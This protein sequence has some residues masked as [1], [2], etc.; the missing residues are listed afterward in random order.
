MDVTLELGSSGGELNK[1]LT[2]LRSHFSELNKSTRE[3]MQL[4]KEAAQSNVASADLWLAKEKEL[5]AASKRQAEQLANQKKMIK[6]LQEQMKSLKETGLD[7]QQAKK[8][9]DEI[10]RLKK[11]ID[12]LKTSMKV[13]GKEKVF[14][15]GSL[16][17]AE[18]SLKRITAEVKNLTKEQLKS[19][20]GKFLVREMKEAQKEVAQLKLEAGLAGKAVGSIEEGAKKSSVAMNALNKSWSFIRQAA[21]IIP[22]LGIAGMIGLATDAIMDLISAMQKGDDI[23]KNFKEINLEAGKAVTEEK[24]RLEAAVKV[25]KDKNATDE[26]RKNALKAI[27]DLMPD[28]IGNITAE[29]INTEEGTRLLKE[30]VKQ[31]D[32]K[33]RGQAY[34]TKIA[35]LY[36]QLLDV[37]N[38]AIEDNIKW[39]ERLWNVVKSGGNLQRQLT[40]DAT[41]GAMNRLQAQKKVQDQILKLEEDL[42]KEL[43]AGTARIDEEEEK[44]V[45]ERR[46][47]AF[48]D[49]SAQILALEKQLLD[50]RIAAMRE[51]R[52]KEIAQEDARYQ[53]AIDKAVDNARKAQEAIDKVRKEKNISEVDRSR[54][55]AQLQEIIKL[56]GRVEEEEKSSHRARLLAIDLKYYEDARK[57]LEASQ[58]STNEIISTGEQKEIAATTQKYAKLF[59]AIEDARKKAMQT[60]DSPLVMAGINFEF[61]DQIAK[62]TEAQQKEL[63]AITR[64]YNLQKIAEGEKLAISEAGILEKSG[65][66]LT[67]LER[68]RQGER[69]KV[70]IIAA[71][72]R[73]KL[74]KDSTATE[75]KIIVADMKALIVKLKDELK[76]LGIKDRKEFSIYSML[77]LND[78]DPQMRRDI[79]Q[80]LQST[81]NSLLSIWGDY[82]DRRVKEQERLMQKI[83]DDLAKQEEIVDREKALKEKGYA[84]DYDLEQR[85]LQDLKNRN[86]AQLEQLKKA[87]KEQAN[88]AKT[89]QILSG[90]ITATKLTVAAAEY[91]AGG[92]TYGPVAGAILSAAAIAA[93]FAAFSAAKSKASEVS[94][95][96]GFQVM[97]GGGEVDATGS[98]Y[99]RHEQGGI[100]VISQ[101]KKVAE[102]EQGE[103]MYVFKDGKQAKK[104]KSFF[105]DINEGR[106][107]DWR[108]SAKGLHLPKDTV[109]NIVVT[110]SGGGLTPVDN[111]HLASIDKKMTKLV[112][113]K[114]TVEIKDGKRIETTGNYIRIT[115]LP[116]NAK[117]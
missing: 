74:L 45:N 108:V 88:Y 48:Q 22:G 2:E 95:N 81:V 16:A 84:N 15:E 110:H 106:L 55:I 80:G 107:S 65:L 96:S 100:D 32:A 109:K 19:K 17:E 70:Q 116:K 27:N 6:E 113:E 36:N 33:A 115:K 11:Q 25:A 112:A 29:N 69:Y 38:S 51:G 71:E 5:L 63:L 98:G 52:E 60:T 4:N 62:L 79:E 18:A 111:K 105:D 99:K 91:F 75:D 76:K 42:A 72:A 103:Y 49:R 90:V 87:Q 73:I 92:A 97:R 67:Q 117:L 26:A 41:Q 31:L 56:E 35:S 59:A 47:R 44:K 86:N 9:A 21:Y 66:T 24:V 3:N 14:A 78:M 40:M 58:L 12:E 30:Y 64:K 77:G 85:K 23:A 54:E 20:D 7:P 39:Y 50:A 61:D 94:S 114:T 8:Y 13:A 34:V 43:N 104:Y 68:Y 83:Q 46:L 82:V 93:M 37:E 89:Q 101:G 53:V 28:H 10:A 102:F 1:Q 57:A